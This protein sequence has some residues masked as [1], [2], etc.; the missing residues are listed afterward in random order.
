MGSEAARLRRE[1]AGSGLRWRG[2]SS[3]LGSPELSD[4]NLKQGLISGSGPLS[5]WRGSLPRGARGPF[6]LQQDLLMGRHLGGPAHAL[7]LGLVLKGEKKV[8]EASGWAW[9]KCLRDA[10]TPNSS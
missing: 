3:A 2:D 1:G 6:A 9:L 8:R 5:P 7:S 4:A 10:Y